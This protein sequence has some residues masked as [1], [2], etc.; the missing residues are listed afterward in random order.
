M[1]QNTQKLHSRTKYYKASKSLSPCQL[2]LVFGLFGCLAHATFL[3][4]PILSYYCNYCLNWY[5]QCYLV[6]MK[7]TGLAQ[8]NGASGGVTNLNL[9]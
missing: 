1:L 9:I 7:V 4:D 5:L 2:F 6:K 3:T 8:E